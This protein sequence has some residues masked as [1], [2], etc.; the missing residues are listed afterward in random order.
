MSNSRI[1]LIA[2][3]IIFAALAI[4]L[5][6]FMP[7]WVPPA[8]PY[9]GPT[10]YATQPASNQ[11]AVLRAGPAID[12]VIIVGSKVTAM[13]AIHS[14]GRITHEA[15]AAGRPIFPRRTTYASVLWGGRRIKAGPSAR[16]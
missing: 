8:P 2:G 15:T 4:G 11:I 5:I 3:T 12:H 14:P 9:S 10:L 1:A 6:Q 16:A 13:A 7:I